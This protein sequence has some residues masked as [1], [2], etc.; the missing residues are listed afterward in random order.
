MDKDEF[1][2]ALADRFTA[3]ELVDLLDVDV[4]QII[5]AFDWEIIESKN[6]LM[7]ILK[8]GEL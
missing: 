7:E 5:E 2:K 6:E 8:Y 3:A 1:E 4:W